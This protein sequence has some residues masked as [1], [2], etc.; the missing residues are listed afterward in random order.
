[1]TSVTLRKADKLYAL[2]RMVRAKF[3]ER[4]AKL[5]ERRAAL[6]QKVYDETLG[7]VGYALRAT[8][9]SDW[10]HWLD[11]S[12]VLYLTDVPFPYCAVDTG[13][14]ET[15]YTS[16]EVDEFGIGLPERSSNLFR[17][18]PEVSLKRTVVVPADRAPRVQV[19]NA[20]ATARKQ[21]GALKRDVTRFNR[22][23]KKFYQDAYNVLMQLRSTRKVDAAF[24]ELWR[25]LPDGLRERVKQ[26]VVPLDQAEI[27]RVRKQ[28]P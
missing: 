18:G 26:A 20:S 12:A 23:A 8:A 7:K 11:T 21:A 6:T 28:L 1:M 3:G 13:K 17:Y 24:P 9:G 5:M 2:R 14:R 25:Y 15:F 16:S 10:K 4:H 19:G 22:D 27:D